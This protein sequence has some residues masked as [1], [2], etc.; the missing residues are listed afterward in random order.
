MGTSGVSE[1]LRIVGASTTTVDGSSVS[2]ESD[3]GDQSDND[4]SKPSE[5]W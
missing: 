5:R 1:A 3:K 2:E 4:L